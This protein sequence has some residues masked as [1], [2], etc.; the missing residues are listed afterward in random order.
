M[1]T[2]T[3]P[4]TLIQAE[5]PVRSVLLSTGVLVAALGVTVAVLIALASFV[6]TWA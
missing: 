6:E 3:Q 1:N 4:S 5:H 2:L